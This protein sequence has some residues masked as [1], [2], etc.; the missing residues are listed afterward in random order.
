MGDPQIFRQIVES[1]PNGIMVCDLDGRIL[2]AN[3]VANDYLHLRNKSHTDDLDDRISS[4]LSSARNGDTETFELHGHT[5]QLLYNDRI[6]GGQRSGAI[7]Y[8]TN[9]DDR[10]KQEFTA[11]VSHELKTPL[12]SISGYAEMIETGMAKQED[13]QKFA[14]RINREAK[15]MLKLV[16]DIIKLTELDETQIMAEAEQVD[17]YQLAQEN[18]ETL[19]AA[20]MRQNTTI[21]LTGEPSVVTGNRALLSELIYN[22]VDNAIRYN[23]DNGSV[24]VRVHHHVLTVRDTGIG[25]PKAHQARIF[26]RF[27][28]VDKSRSKATGGTGL[29]LAIV[30]QICEQH[31]AQIRLESREGV[32]TE[33]SV[34]FPT[35]HED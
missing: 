16:T 5:V 26:E 15:R 25:I 30:R 10:R 22:L 3:E 17:L 2:Y 13:I 4:F 6:S 12:T 14:A 11:N 34:T 27:Y 28:R 20:A 33:I 19:E 9:M 18:I 35:F 29:G 32:G 21:S 1:L 24:S 8:L 23:R 7:L 31:H